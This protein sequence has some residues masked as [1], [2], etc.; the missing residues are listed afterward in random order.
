MGG[1]ITWKCIKSGN[2]SG[3][4]VF[5]VKVYRDCQGV[6]IATSMNLQTHNIPNMSSIPLNW[7]EATD[8]SPTCDT[9]NG[10]NDPFSCNGQN[11]QYSTNDAGAVEEHIYRSDTIRL[12]GTPNSDGWHFTWN[13]WCRNNAID[14]ISNP[15]SYGFT[16]RAVMYPYTDSLGTIYPNNNPPIS[17]I[18]PMVTVLNI[19]I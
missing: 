1:E 14:N 5:E 16:L 9:I 13:S 3:F 17:A 18:I 4:Y 10:P 19:L 8:I 11:I 12:I 15:G 2:K 6:A 7:I